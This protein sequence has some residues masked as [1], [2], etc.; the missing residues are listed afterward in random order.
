MSLYSSAPRPIAPEDYNRYFIA[1]R[2]SK[3]ELDNA[4]KNGKNDHLSRS[5]NL[6]TQADMKGVEHCYICMDPYSTDKTSRL[7]DRHDAI[8]LPCGHIFGRAC[9]LTWSNP[10]DAPPNNSCPLCRMAP[11]N[12]ITNHRIVSTVLIR[13]RLDQKRWICEIAHI[14]PNIVNRW[15]PASEIPYV[16]KDEPLYRLLPKEKDE[17]WAAVAEDLW[18]ALCEEAV[19]Y[20]EI[21]DFELMPFYYHRTAAPLAAY[22]ADCVTLERFNQDRTSTNVKQA[23]NARYLR[24]AY[25]RTYRPLEEYLDWGDDFRPGSR[26]PWRQHNFFIRPD[27]RTYE[28]V[29]GYH[30]RIEATKVKLLASLAKSVRIGRS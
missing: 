9:F 3:Q 29:A 27:A 16:P 10:R 4:I 7:I 23:I 25:P 30:R 13:D 24:H 21:T 5:C 14:P 20:L 28:R 26:R 17:K 22:L 8:K 12:R 1:P 19:R 2:S 18:V 6:P 15:D 11:I